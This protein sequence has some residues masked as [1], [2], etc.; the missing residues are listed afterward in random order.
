[1]S[2]V[3]GALGAIQVGTIMSQPLPTAQGYEDGYG[4]E[5][6]IT[7][8]QDGKRFN[9]RRSRLKSG[10]VDRPTHFI[11]GENNKVEMVIDNPTWT[12]YTPQLKNAIYAAN[13]RA[14]GFESG[15]NMKKESTQ[16]S[17]GNDEIMIKMMSLMSKNIEVLEY[18]RDTPP[19]AIIQKNARNGKEVDE[20]RQEY[21]DLKNKNKH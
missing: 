12:S 8:Q 1:M 14:N 11:A 5:Y 13:A 19:I 6:P 15:F 16:A 7:R 2:G 4:M 10:L 18:I 21:L 3:V 20:M 17:G 9:V